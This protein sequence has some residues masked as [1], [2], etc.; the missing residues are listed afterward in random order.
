[1]DF[2][3]NYETIICFIVLFCMSKTYSERY[4]LLKF[5]KP[6]RGVP[7]PFIVTEEDLYW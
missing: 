3:Q 5:H 7:R 4:Q 6:I 2:Q 1:M